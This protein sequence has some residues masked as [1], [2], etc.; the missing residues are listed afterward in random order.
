MTTRAVPSVDDFLVGSPTEDAPIERIRAHAKHVDRGG[1]AELRPHGDPEWLP[2]LVE[3]VGEVARALCD[4]DPMPHLREELVQVAAMACA[5][6]G[7]I[8]AHG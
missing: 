8:D 2:L 4:R 1:S 7:A 5:W 6:I 3:E